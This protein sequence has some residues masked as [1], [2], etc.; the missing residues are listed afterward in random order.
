MT[1]TVTNADTLIGFEDEL[2]EAMGAHDNNADHKSEAHAVSGISRAEGGRDEKGLVTPQVSGAPQAGGN[3]AISVL[4]SDDDIEDLLKGAGDELARPGH[5]PADKGDEPV[6]RAP[7]ST[8]NQI[9]GAPTVDTI[10]DAIRAGIENL[11]DLAHADI[12]LDFVKKHRLFET[13]MK[14]L[15]AEIDEDYE[16]GH[17]DGDPAE[18]YVHWTGWISAKDASSLQDWGKLVFSTFPGSNLILPQTTIHV[19]SLVLGPTPSWLG[20]LVL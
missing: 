5:K 19:R 2:Q 18:D 9:S 12:L 1:D 7:K 15:R 10:S 14:V 17:P 16:F 20:G 3:Q 6:Q 4:E 13:Y 8:G 11:E